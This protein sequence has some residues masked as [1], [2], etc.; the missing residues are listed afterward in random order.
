MMR[1]IAATNEA[2]KNNPV[3]VVYYRCEVE[4]GKCIPHGDFYYVHNGVALEHLPPNNH[5]VRI[6]HVA[7]W[8]D[9]NEVYIFGKKDAAQAVKDGKGKTDCCGSEEVPIKDTIWRPW[10]WVAIYPY[11]DDHHQLLVDHQPIAWMVDHKLNDPHNGVLDLLECSKGECTLHYQH[12]KNKNPDKTKGEDARTVHDPTGTE[13][14]K[15]F[16]QEKGSV[17]VK[18]GQTAN[19]GLTIATQP[20]VTKL[21]PCP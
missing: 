1:N 5:R 9:T 10:V 8:P 14:Q 16:Q 13:W 15:K 7:T 11:L 3:A 20:P 4:K 21:S 19:G 17:T 12:F 6:S 18:A 2:E